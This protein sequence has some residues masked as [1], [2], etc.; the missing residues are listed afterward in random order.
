MNCGQAGV[1]VTAYLKAGLSPAR[2]RAV[3]DRVATCDACSLAVREAM[4]LEGELFA[5]AARHR[6]TLSPEVSARIQERVYRR[7]RR[8][9]MFARLS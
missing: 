3:R 7:M 4:T 2:Q 8:S 9:I 1:Q 6:P 5:E